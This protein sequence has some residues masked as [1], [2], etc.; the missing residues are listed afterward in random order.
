MIEGWGL[1]AAA[2]VAGGAV[3]G[4]AI[5]SSAAKNAAGQQVAAEQSALGQQQQMFQQEQTNEQPYMQLGQ[6]ASS[7]LNYLLGQGTPGT[8]GT[9]ASSTGGAFGSLNKPF[10]MN[11]F[12][13]LTPQ[14][15]FDLQQGGQGVL[16]QNASGQGAESPAALAALESYNSGYANNSFNS[17]FANYNTQKNNIFDRLSGLAT[18]GS[19]AGSNS[20]TGASN[21]SG[22][23]GNTTSSIGASQAAGT[24]GSANAISGGIQSGANAFYGQNALNQ[25]LNGGSTVT[26]DPSS[27]M[28]DWS[29][30]AVAGALNSGQP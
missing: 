25:I 6:G 17:A 14:Y 29:N 11:D 2:V 30:S 10:D 28:N 5:S 7:Q 24:V 8:G 23:I 12:K 9:A 16:N 13:S 21:F 18:L 15:Q 20:A 4:A 3:A 1:A 22:Q 27:Q 26:Y 19:N